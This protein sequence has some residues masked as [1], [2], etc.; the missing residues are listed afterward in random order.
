MVFM[1][2]FN[3]P[4]R[5]KVYRVF[6]FIG[7][8]I[9]LLPFLYEIIGIGQLILL[10][11]I[12]VLAEFRYRL[13]EKIINKQSV[14]SFM[15]SLL[16]SV[17]ILLICHFYPN[18]AFSELLTGT[19]MRT[20]YLIVQIIGLTVIV[21][22]FFCCIF[23]KVIDKKEFTHSKYINSLVV[24]GTL[25][26]TFFI[27]FP[28]DSYLNNLSDFSFPI[29]S[30]IWYELL[31][32][33]FF[34][35]GVSA[36]VSFMKNR[37]F[38]I[39]I[40]FFTAIDICVY[41]Q[42]MFLNQKLILI[43]GESMNWENYKMFSV[44]TF[45]LWITVITGIIIA[46]F[47]KHALFE[48]VI[49][50]IPLLISGIQ[51][52]TVFIMILSADSK[53]F[54][55]KTAYLSAE[56]QYTVSSDENVIMFILD[57]TDNSY[58]EE[59]LKNNP[60][61]FEGY[62]DF[63]LYTNTCSVLDFT[64]TSVT[65][66]FTGMDF[67]YDISM[68][69]WIDNSWNSLKAND[70]YDRFHKAGYIV[71]SFDWSFSDERNRI[72]KLDNCVVAKDTSG[73]LDLKINISGV[74]KDFRKLSLY[75]A[76]P[77]LFKKYV[78]YENIDFYLHV[79]ASDMINYF[80]YD[81]ERDLALKLSEKKNSYF[82]VQHLHGTHTPCD[83]F[84]GESEHLLKVIRNYIEQ[85]KE[86]GVYDK[87]SIIITADH[88]QHND[89]NHETASTPVFMIK[90]KNTSNHEMIISGAPVYHEDIQA[91]LLDCAG[92]YDKEN[93]EEYFGRSV[94]DLDENE[95]RTRTW[96]DRVNGGYYVY[97]YTGDTEE[98]R[99]MAAADAPTK[100]IKVND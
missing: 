77:F 3:R 4:V 31:F 49:G 94:F 28:C 87:S 90:R 18:Y 67:D 66:M 75:R 68:E 72:G 38:R 84:I 51:I 99:K 92:L 21:Y 86:Y 52:L 26:F 36:A 47:K 41:I 100:K 76:Y 73:D 1:Q 59:I 23:T 95:L 30:F 88:G 48:K 97:V 80:N 57:A 5:Y 37:I 42:Y 93:D 62:E 6:F 98:L 39:V 44:L 40:S 7:L 55:Y 43:D 29:Q 10:M 79:S 33:L 53:A 65:Q 22:P 8:L 14:I 25:F 27:Y 69:E 50:K 83:D 19:W 91:T 9:F 16:F 13:L 15:L 85:L 17:Y 89:G 61:V 24:T 96:I 81:Y 64:K 34:S 56:E 70:F 63:T 82:I 12:S 71:N 60:D 58:F 46:E 2:L 35:A 32:F 54:E 45:M 78:D 74:L 11:G 20:V